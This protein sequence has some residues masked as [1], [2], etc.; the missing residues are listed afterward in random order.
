MLD[1]QR[2]LAG[3][4]VRPD[5][6]HAAVHH[7]L[8]CVGHG[9]GPQRRVGAIHR[10]ALFIALTVAG[11]V[12]RTIGSIAAALTVAALTVPALAIAAALAI[13]LIAVAA[14]V[15]GPPVAVTKLGL[16]QDA[17]IG[18]DLL[19]DLGGRVGARARSGQDR[20]Q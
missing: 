15:P 10:D 12:A 1:L 8:G 16:Q 19:V 9:I 13:A 20:G 6:D 5:I 7:P 2:F 17:E 4:A 14:P 18:T 11:S 3:D